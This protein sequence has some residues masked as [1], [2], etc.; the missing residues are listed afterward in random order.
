MTLAPPLA[1]DWGMW[2]AAAECTEIKAI[3]RLWLSDMP[4]VS[5]PELTDTLSFP[6]SEVL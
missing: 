6:H 1:G 3:G 5:F 2:V 4:W